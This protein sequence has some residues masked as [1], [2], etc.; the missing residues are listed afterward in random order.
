MSPTREN[1]VT[2]LRRSVPVRALGDHIPDGDGFVS[3][4]R[5]RRLY[6]QLAGLVERGLSQSFEVPPGV[7]LRH[8]PPHVSEQLLRRRGS[9]RYVV[10]APQAVGCG[11]RSAPHSS[12]FFN[13]EADAE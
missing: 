5:A 7:R 6:K 13:R 9:Y 2:T 1:L 12:A 4:F 8:I 3:F 10:A 11:N